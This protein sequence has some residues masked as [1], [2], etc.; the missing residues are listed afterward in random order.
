[1][2]TAPLTPTI[3]KRPKSIAVPAAATTAVSTGNT[4]AANANGTVSGSEAKKVILPTKD[5]KRSL[6]AAQNTDSLRS[7]SSANSHVSSLHGAAAGGGVPNED[8]RHKVKRIRLEHE[9]QRALHS[10][11][12]TVG[13][14]SS[15]TGTGPVNDENATPS[16]ALAATLASAPPTEDSECSNDYGNHYIVDEDESVDMVNTGDSLPPSYAALDGHIAEWKA[17]DDAREDR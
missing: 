6:S 4:T 10:H 14:S 16:A 8:P 15:D 3:S 1:M 13:S 17:Q 5:H 2:N 12:A 7:S 9:Q 11:A